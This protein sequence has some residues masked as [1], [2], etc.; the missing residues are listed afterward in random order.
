MNKKKFSLGKRSVLQ[1]NV[2]HGLKSTSQHH[3][4][5]YKPYYRLIE[6]L[7]ETIHLVNCSRITVEIFTRPTLVVKFYCVCVLCF[8]VW[9]FFFNGTPEFSSLGG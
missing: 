5:F 9:F 6:N 1:Q 3:L 7:H 2:V 8:I 4:S